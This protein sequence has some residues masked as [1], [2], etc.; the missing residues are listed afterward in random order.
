MNT[1]LDPEVRKEIFEKLLENHDF[2]VSR[3]MLQIIKQICKHRKA[4][5]VF[6]VLLKCLSIFVLIVNIG[7]A[8][9]K[10]IENINIFILAMIFFMC[11]LIGLSLLPVTKDENGELIP[12]DPEP[13]SIIMAI[14]PMLTIFFLVVGIITLL[15]Y[16][17][18]LI[19]S[20]FGFRLFIIL[21]MGTTIYLFNKL[22]DEMNHKIYATLDV[23]SIIEEMLKPEE[24]NT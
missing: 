10:N 24:P 13:D 21:A 23:I 2:V 12:L 11:H 14:I 6:L 9:A 3:Q 5:F 17:I 7:L 16:T 8:L 15:V 1:E 19:V 20:G 18:S 22:C 4:M